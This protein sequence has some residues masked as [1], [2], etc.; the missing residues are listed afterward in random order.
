MMQ[1]SGERRRENANAYLQ[2]SLRGAAWIA[3]LTLAMTEKYAV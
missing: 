3:S 2:P 1:D